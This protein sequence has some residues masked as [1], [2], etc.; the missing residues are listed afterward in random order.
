MIDKNDI[1]FKVVLGEGIVP[2]KVQ[3]EL[4]D[5]IAHKIGNAIVESRAGSGKSKTIEL[6]A[7]F[8]PKGKK[9]LI[10]CFNTH[11]AEHLKN[12]LSQ[13][14]VNAD[15]MTYHSLGYKILLSKKIISGNNKFKDDKYRNF[16]INN[17]NTI[18]PKY[19]QLN[20][21]EK[22]FY[23]KNILKLIDYSRYNL[24]QSEKEIRKIA[25]KYGIN[26]VDNECEAVK[27]ILRWGSNNFNEF[28]YQDMIWLP[29][30][31]GI[32]ANIPWLQYDYIF[33]DEA[34]DSSLAQQNLINICSKRTTRLIIVGDSKQC[35]NSWAGSDEE[36]FNNFRKKG[37]MK[38]FVLSTSYRCSRKI[39]ELAKMYVPDFNVPKWASEGEVNYD[40]SLDNIRPGDMV[41]CRLTSPLVDLHLRLISNKLPSKIKGLELGEE[42]KSILNTYKTNDITELRCE[43]EKDLVNKWVNISKENEISL[44]EAACEND[45]MI[46]YDTLLTLNIISKGLS[47]KKEVIERIDSVIGSEDEN[48]EDTDNIHLTTIHKAKGL[49]NE[50]VFILCPSLMPSRLAH[51][52]WEIKSEQNLIYVAYTR[53]KKSLNFLSEKEFPPSVS[54]SGVD[55]MYNTL[56]KLKEKYGN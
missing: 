1:R 50:R 53:A 5:F 8:V 43:M 34:Q 14:E 47:T 19:E 44:K 20:N 9:T 38:E 29:Y 45:I 22:N 37:N 16:I 56:M 10:V 48:I 49:E 3:V 7:H 54:Y 18:N 46:L 35:I 26:C 32:N 41:L 23:K 13:Q 11:I 40:V 36:A 24:M 39:A 55:N 2:S 30:E 15:V 31:L 25:N 12:E 17:I 6:M 42:L 28:D 27:N 33:V 51:K 52:D 21:I 4:C